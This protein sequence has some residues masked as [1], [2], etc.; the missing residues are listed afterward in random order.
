MANSEDFF[1]VT[2]FSCF[3]EHEGVII[4]AMFWS[5]QAKEAKGN[6]G[7]T[8]IAVEALVMSNSTGES[9]SGRNLWRMG[10]FGSRFADGSGP[11]LGYINQLL[12]SGQ[13]STTLAAGK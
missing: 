2:F 8:V 3:H 6:T 1:H 5:A 10:I 9:I 12:D 4:D 13:A 11:R 7:D